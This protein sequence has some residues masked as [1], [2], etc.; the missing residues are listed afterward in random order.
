MNP[1]EGRH[2]HSSLA[3]I[4]TV[5]NQEL[6]LISGKQTG[7]GGWGVESLSLSLLA[8]LHRTPRGW[9]SGPGG[10]WSWSVSC[11]TPPQSCTPSTG[12]SLMAGKRGFREMTFFLECLSQR[13]FSVTTN[14]GT[15]AE[16]QE[17]RS[18]YP[19]SEWLCE[20]FLLGWA[21]ASGTLSRSVPDQT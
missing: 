6:D 8:S 10:G 11:P 17:E 14:T 9:H 5:L 7:V 19:Y 16:A 18:P 12:N 3:I 20:R 4:L 2:T 13:K 21:K 15:R 1:P